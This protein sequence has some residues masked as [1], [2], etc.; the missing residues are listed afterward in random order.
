MCL[1]TERP[2]QAV[3]AASR[4]MCDRR[5]KTAPSKSLRAV[6]WTL[7][8]MILLVLGFF[9]TKFLLEVRPAG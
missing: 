1:M 5:A 3:A 9:G 4:G 2:V 7:A 8:A 6:R